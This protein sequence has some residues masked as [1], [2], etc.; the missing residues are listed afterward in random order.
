MADQK[1]AALIVSAVA[2]LRQQQYC[3]SMKDVLPYILVLAN[4]ITPLVLF[5]LHW[6]LKGKEGRERDRQKQLQ[7]TFA[8]TVNALIDYIN[9]C[10]SKNEPAYIDGATKADKIVLF[11]AME[12]GRV[13][14]AYG[15]WACPDQVVLSDAEITQQKVRRQMQELRFSTIQRTPLLH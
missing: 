9:V 10:H 3:A 12:Q 5:G 1:R 6:L 2:E 7:P 8:P 15:A 11:E 13:E 4:P 14:I